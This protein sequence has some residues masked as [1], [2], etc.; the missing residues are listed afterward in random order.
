MGDGGSSLIFDSCTLYLAYANIR[1]GAGQN[2]VF[3]SHRKML[4]CTTVVKEN[5]FGECFEMAQDY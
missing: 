4:L 2:N 1:R 5:A 3:M